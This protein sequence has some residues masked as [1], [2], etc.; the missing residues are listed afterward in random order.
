MK[1]ETYHPLQNP[2]AR[3]LLQKKGATFKESLSSDSASSA[4]EAS[5]ATATAPLDTYLVL[6]A[7]PSEFEGVKLATQRASFLLDRLDTLKLALLTGSL[8]LTTLK[9]LKALLKNRRDAFE[10][11]TLKEIIDEIDLRV[12]VEL[13]K[14]SP[15][16]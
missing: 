5:E 14:L 1:I 8:S 7:S 16:T 9:E 12:A 10:D 13:A 6:Q 15:L 11:P 4:K 3:K 2:K